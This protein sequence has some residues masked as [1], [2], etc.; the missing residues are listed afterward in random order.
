MNIILKIL[1]IN[2][3]KIKPMYYLKVTFKKLCLIENPNQVN[4]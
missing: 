4:K 3:L 1:Y 2:L